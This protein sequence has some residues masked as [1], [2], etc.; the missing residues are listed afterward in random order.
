MENNDYAFQQAI[1]QYDSIKENIENL[2]KANKKGNDEE[3]E[4]IQQTIQE[5]PIEVGI[6]RQY[7]IL[8]CTGGPAVRMIGELDEYGEPETARLQYQDW[9]TPWTDYPNA[10]DMEEIMLE[11]ARQFYFGEEGLK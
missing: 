6:I 10:G 1:N 2:R 8:L 7:F 3:I 11:Y 4:S 9:G 5:D